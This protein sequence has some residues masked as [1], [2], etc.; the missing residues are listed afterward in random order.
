MADSVSIR[1]R[2]NLYA[3]SVTLLQVTAEVA[4]LTGVLDAA[5]VMATDLNRD[6]LR[7]SGLLMDEA[8]AAGPNDLIIAVRASDAAAASAALEGAESLL[9]KRRTAPE[10]TSHAAPR[11]IRSAHRA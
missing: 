8:T 4:A 10:A 5:L 11:S 6:L 1:L 9:A 3:D 2:P 7:E